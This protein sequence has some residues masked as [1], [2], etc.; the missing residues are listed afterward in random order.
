MATRRFV[1]ETSHQQRRPNESACSSQ[2]ICV[3]PG[4]CDPT[5]GQQETWYCR[6]NYKP[7]GSEP[8][9]SGSPPSTADLLWQEELSKRCLYA[10]I[11]VVIISAVL[12]RKVKLRSTASLTVGDDPRFASRGDRMRFSEIRLSHSRQHFKSALFDASISP[13]QT[14]RR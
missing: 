4:S 10:A 14:V 12:R 5:R 11:T 3:M 8:L 2:G 13:A 1:F 7:V 6:S 9:F